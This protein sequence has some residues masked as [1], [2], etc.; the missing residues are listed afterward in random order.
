VLLA[1]QFH[2]ELILLVRGHPGFAWS[3]EA[4]NIFP[5]QC[6]REGLLERAEGKS[7]FLRSR[8]AA[9]HAN[10]SVIGRE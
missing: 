7:Q 8:I 6:V 9:I 10:A 1:G 4:L 5:C 3:V 2:N